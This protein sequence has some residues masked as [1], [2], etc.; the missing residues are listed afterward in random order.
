MY[1]TD[2]EGKS[3]ATIYYYYVTYEFQS[4]SEDH[5]I[6]YIGNKTSVNFLEVV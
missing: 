4:E 2:N 3:V 6:H 5:L 1:S